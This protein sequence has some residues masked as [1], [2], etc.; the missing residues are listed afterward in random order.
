MRCKA[1]FTII[2]YMLVLRDQF[3]NVPLMSLQTGSRLGTTYQAIVDPRRLQVVAF[4]CSGPHIDIK[5]AVVHTSDIRELGT[6]GIIIDSSD[7][8]MDPEELPRLLEIINF[9]FQLEGKPVVEE[10]GH[11]VGKVATY[12]LDT[13]TF[14]IAKLHIQPGL[15]QSLTLTEILIDRSQIISVDD[16][17]IV[18]RQAD[19]RAEEPAPKIAISNPFGKPKT[20]AEAIK[21]SEQKAA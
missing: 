16:K 17:K 18:V 9:N 7:K 20:Q 11:K 14:Y 2:Y 3:L 12:T 19:V 13:T 8:I 6:M 1:F 10:N 5:P 4:Y 15:L 21:T